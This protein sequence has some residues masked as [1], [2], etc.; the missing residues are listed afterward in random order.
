MAYNSRKKLNQA[1][2]SLLIKAGALAAAQGGHDSRINLVR[3][4]FVSTAEPRPTHCAPVAAPGR[5]SSLCSYFPSH[6][7]PGLFAFLVCVI[8]A[9]FVLS[10]VAVVHAS[11]GRLPG[12]SG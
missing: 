9:R 1:H 7:P 8:L 5:L 10:A 11:V 6:S 2:I 3:L 12:S 4:I